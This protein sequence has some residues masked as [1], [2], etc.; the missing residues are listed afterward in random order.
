M[1]F[2]IELPPK[3]PLWRIKIYSNII[4]KLG[5]DAIWTSEHYY[6]RSSAIS[7]IAIGQATRKIQICMGILNPYV[8]HPVIIAQ[9]TA[10][11]S[12]IYPGRICLGIGAGDRLTL[13]NLGIQQQAP[14]KKVEETVNTLKKLLESNRYDDYVRLDFKKWGEIP[15]YIAAQGHNMLKLAAKIGDGVLINFTGLDIVQKAVET[16]KETL[17]ANNRILDQFSIEVTVMTSIDE[18]KYK[19]IKTMMPYVAILALG[20]GPNYLQQ[21]G[22]N[23]KKF[24]LLRHHTRA[25]HWPEVQSLVPKDLVDSLSIAGTPAEVHSKI[26]ELLKMPVNGIVFGGPLGPNPRKALIALREVVSQHSS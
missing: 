17:E 13:E 19:A 6:N 1:K 24:E 20:M 7:C 25:G 8:I 21:Y 2:S 16:V 18:N 3:D 10:T 4:E 22:L 12:E 26:L 14:I 15:I 5:F 9:I 23:S 11:L